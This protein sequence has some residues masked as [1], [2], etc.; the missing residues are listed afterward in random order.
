MIVA[1]FKHSREEMDLSQ[2]DI[3]KKLGVHF[4]TVSG[5]ETGKDTI[6][7]RQ[8]I[9]YANLYKLSLDYLFGFKSKNKYI[10]LDI[11]LKEVG[12]KLRIFRK[13][14]GMT[15]VQVAEKLNTSQSAYAH[16]ESGMYLIT[17]Y[18]LYALL[19]VYK[20]ISADEIF[21]KKEN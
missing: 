12:K 8:L 7:L 18:F 15:Q 10:K 19:T 5:W 13:R 2:R 1:N 4:S 14:H 9:K 16:Y 6:P 17:T 21:M 20:D 3:A 11:D